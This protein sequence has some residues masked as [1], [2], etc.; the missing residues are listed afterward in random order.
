VSQFPIETEVEPV[1]LED[2]LAQLEVEFEQAKAT[3]EFQYGVNV[4]LTIHNYREQQRN[5]AP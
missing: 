4:M 5:A 2:R 1:L 3:L